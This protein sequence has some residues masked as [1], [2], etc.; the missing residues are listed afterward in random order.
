MLIQ[1]E[2]PF[3]KFRKTHRDLKQCEMLLF[4]CTHCGGWEF[5]APH[6]RTEQSKA[7]KDSSSDSMQ[8]TFQ[9]MENM[10]R[11]GIYF[12]IFFTWAF[13]YIQKFKGFF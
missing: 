4:K 6:G 2:C 7:R 13:E 3:D 12:P 11:S 5:Q 10:Y 8:H 1:A 9:K